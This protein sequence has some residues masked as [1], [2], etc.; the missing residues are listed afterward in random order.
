MEET[1]PLSKEDLI[2]KRIHFGDRIKVLLSQEGI[3]QA[4]LARMLGLSP[5]SINITLGKGSRYPATYLYSL[6]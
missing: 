6:N 2:S 4:D 5:Q 1:A 3:K